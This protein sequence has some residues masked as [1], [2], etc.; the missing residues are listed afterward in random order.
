MYNEDFEC[1]PPQTR[2]DARETALQ[3]LYAMEISGNSMNAVLGDLL[4]KCPSPPQ[5]L[6][7]CTKIVELTFSGRKELDDYIQK[8][9]A[10]WKF[11]RIALLDLIV[12]RI[13]ICELLHFYDV[14]PKVSI[15]EALELAKKYSTY[16]S[17]GFINGILDAILLDLQESNM[18]IKTG[19]GKQNNPV[20]K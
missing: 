7:F 10:N 6:S 1:S 8:Y 2:H 4:P 5:A 3:L 11:D 15:D 16:K 20:K 14:P 9:S 13:A 12:M 17:S 19:R 18:I